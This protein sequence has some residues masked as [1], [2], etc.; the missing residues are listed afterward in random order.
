MR[1]LFKSFCYTLFKG[2]TNIW[3]LVFFAV[4]LLLLLIIVGY[5]PTDAGWS[6][7]GNNLPVKHYLGSFGAYFADFFLSFL[8]YASYGLIAGLFFIGWQNINR[9]KY[10]S[11]IIIWKIL[12]LVF[13]LLSLTSILSLYWKTDITPIAKT[14]GGGLGQLLNNLFDNALNIPKVKFAN[15]LVLVISTSF[16]FGINWLGIGK[17]LFKSIIGL[18]VL[19][20]AL[21]VKLVAKL[22]ANKNKAKKHDLPK[23]ELTNADN[24]AVNQSAD[25]DNNRRR[26]E[27]SFAD[28]MQNSQ[29]KAV[30]KEQPKEE[31]FVNQD[32]SHLKEEVVVNE[33]K[34]SINQ[35]F[36]KEKEYSDNPVVNDNLIEEAVINQTETSIKNQ[37][38]SDDV[39]EQQG[40]NDQEINLQKNEIKSSDQKEEIVI[41]PAENPFSIKIYSD[42]L[43]NKN[44]SDQIDLTNNDEIKAVNLNNTLL[45]N[46]FI[47][48]DQDKEGYQLPPLNLFSPPKPRQFTPTAS[49]L[50]QIAQRV[51][52]VLRDYKLEVKVANIEVGPVITR[53]ELAL[54]AGIKV[55]QISVLDK[56]LARILAV[57]SVRV[58]EVIPGKPYVGLE[59]PNAHR[60]TVSLRKLLESSAYQNSQS[61][62]TLILGEDIAG[63]P[64]VAELDKM[65]HLLVA[66]TTGSGKSVGINVMLA[67]MLCKAKPADL[68][69]ILVD[70]KMLEMSMY[71][72]IPHLL[73][74]VVTDMN[75]A[76]NALRW[77]VAEME[78]R[79]QLMAELKVRNL[80][81]F[82]QAIIDAQNKGETIADPTWNPEDYVGIAHQP[83]ALK[84][85]PHIVI[86]IDEL[87]DMMMVVGKKV[88]E[89]IARIAQKAR[90]AGI[91]LILATQRPSVDVITGLIKA[92]VPTRIAFQVSSKIDS[93]TILEQQGAE[94]LL[95]N[96]DML[97]SKPGSAP[98][99]RVHGAFVSD[100]EV[101]DLTSF[102]KSQG[103]PEYEQ[104]IINPVP[105]SALG[106][107]GSLDKFDDAETNDPLY[108]EAVSLVLENKKAS[109]SWLQRRLSIG[110]NRSARIIEAM[111]RA[112]LVSPQQNGTRRVLVD[113]EEM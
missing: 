42:D 71:A 15:W 19:I 68:R 66:G 80:A 9:K 69:L 22:F 97:Y 111:E 26:D 94:S 36:D 73:T 85:L 18:I 81:G 70:P 34:A 89:L 79:Y 52:Q 16:V 105:A 64:V 55:S 65:P 110:Y 95:G 53:L 67:S 46:D 51:E 12:G 91:H 106:A 72:D 104:S 98:P 5:Q 11:E 29:E 49:E 75:E 101:D 27:P 21:A 4:S 8:G 61:K 14:A 10:Q 102:V 92:N 6:H 62:L 23:E 108:D 3:F 17:I 112:G 2:L 60:E 30:G 88:E 109:I 96:G 24:F 48:N 38:I 113:K 54:A 44:Q 90:A 107:I 31:I 82:N 37:I 103:S 28:F 40:I 100:K 63:M 93:R 7:S 83:P 32:N 45:E 50:Q 56:D 20:F 41:N 58:V 76:E 43:A 74:P 84:T 99:Q 25:N 35:E 59:L 39:G 33:E 87:A 47:N 57:Q 77:A 1:E 78:R 86:V 13:F